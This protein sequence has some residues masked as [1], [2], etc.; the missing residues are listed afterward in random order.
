MRTFIIFLLCLFTYIDPCF[1]QTEN[2][3]ITYWLS[4]IADGVY[5]LHQP[6]F[7]PSKN[8][9]SEY[10]KSFPQLE[11]APKEHFLSFV[12]ETR[13]ADNCWELADGARIPESRRIHYDT[14]IVDIDIVSKI[15][16]RK[17]PIINTFEYDKE[18]YRGRDPKYICHAYQGVAGSFDYLG[19]VQMRLVIMLLTSGDYR[20]CR[21]AE[22]LRNYIETP[23]SRDI[24]VW[25]LRDK[26]AKLHYGTGV[27]AIFPSLLSEYISQC[28]KTHN[29][30]GR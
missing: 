2:D 14:K 26:E 11:T 29:K 12:R 25:S 19:L 23:F 15:L 8:S 13:F 4:K 28:H 27:L 17:T 10:V 20:F 9:N 22:D 24:D 1:A 6:M 3:V 5:D 21:E 30:S 18:Q 16:S 7:P